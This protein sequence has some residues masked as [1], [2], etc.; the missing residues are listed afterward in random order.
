MSDGERPP[1]GTSW[2]VELDQ[3]L[4]LKEEIRTGEDQL[5]IRRFVN[6]AFW[7]TGSAGVLAGVAALC[8]TILLAGRVSWSDLAR[9]DGACAVLAAACG[10]LNWRVRARVN[11]TAFSSRSV[12]E[13]RLERARE[14]LRH[15]AATTYP[16]VGVRHH[17]YREDVSDFIGLYQAESLKYRRVHNWLQSTIIIGSLLTTTIAA[18]ADALPAH[19]WT[20]VAVSFT[21]GLAAGFTG[22]FK[23]RER[24]FYLQLTADAIEQE[25]NAAVLHV[26]DYAGLGSEAEVLSRLTDRVEALRGEQRR[27]QQQLDQPTENHEAAT[28]LP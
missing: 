4:L 20:T 8:L 2:S 16:E 12:L 24:S 15:F 22:Y 14:S 9:L 18:L 1:G 3:L 10:I 26:G 27:R 21:V 5:R 7:T 19:R 11:R 13:G 23:F 28:A 17:Y 6:L 25:L